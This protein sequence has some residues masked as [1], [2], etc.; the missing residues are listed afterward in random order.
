MVDYLSDPDARIE[1]LSYFIVT[2]LGFSFWYFMAVPFASHRET[3][4]RFAMTPTHGFATAFAVISVTYRPVA[5]GVTWLAFL[6]LNPSIFP[7]SV[8]RQALFQGFV[9]GMFVL[10]WWL[11][12]RAAPQR[13]LFA[14]VAFVA[15][16]VFFPGYIHLFHIYGI[17]YVARDADSW[18][19]ALLIR[20]KT[21]S[22]NA[23]CG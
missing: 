20:L 4:W 11:I 21:H 22:R 2:L 13:R 23:N 16:G 9:Y 8:L 15:G 17:M 10:A 1:T 12:Y 3:Y 18:R 19:P 5:Q 7:T 14:M 6:I